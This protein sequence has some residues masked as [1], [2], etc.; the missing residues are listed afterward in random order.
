MKPIYVTTDTHFGHQMMSSKFGIRPEGFEKIILRHLSKL[1]ED[2]TLV[3]LGDFCI[4]ADEEWVKTFMDTVPCRRKIL[5][6]GNHDNKSDTWYYDR[7]WSFVCSSFIL[8]LFGK[9][10]LFSHIPK[11][12]T[13]YPYTEVN[14]HGHTHG[15]MHRDI[16]VRDIYDPEYHIEIALEK[17]D[18]QPTMLTDKLIRMGVKG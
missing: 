1:P 3:H 10:V 5:V 14:V 6:R 15:D 8:R 17:M 13:H 7:G 2:A 12:H 4:G 9:R 11:D 18:Y 16:E